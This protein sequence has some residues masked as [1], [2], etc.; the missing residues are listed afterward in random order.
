MTAKTGKPEREGPH[1]VILGTGPKERPPM[2]KGLLKPPG[3]NPNGEAQES[4]PT[5]EEG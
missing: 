1:I 4:G 5:S 2:P 3:A